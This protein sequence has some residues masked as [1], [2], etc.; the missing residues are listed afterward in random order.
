[1]SNYELYGRMA[2]AVKSIGGEVIES[3]YY[4]NGYMIVEGVLPDGRKTTF[5]VEERKD[6]HRG[7]S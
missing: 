3:H 7:E 1:M 6:E 5:Y 2:S 4:S